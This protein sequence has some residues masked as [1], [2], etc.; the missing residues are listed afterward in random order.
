MK[1]LENLPHGISSEMVSLGYLADSLLP[2]VYTA[3]PQLSALKATG[4]T[5][6]LH[7]KLSTISRANI[8]TASLIAL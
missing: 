8:T 6:K 5:E 4:A 2:L 7:S 1:A 3:A